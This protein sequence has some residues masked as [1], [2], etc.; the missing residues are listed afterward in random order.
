M[1]QHLC[2]KLL[3]CAEVLM[4]NFLQKYLWSLKPYFYG[5]IVCDVFELLNAWL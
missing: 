3:L 2:F 1:K 4:L 5:C